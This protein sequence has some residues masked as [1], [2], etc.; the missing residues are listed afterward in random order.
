MRLNEE[1]REALKVAALASVAAVTSMG[2]AMHKRRLLP[3]LLA[4]GSACC[5]AGAI[6]YLDGTYRVAEATEI[7]DDTAEL[8]DE[9]ECKEAESRM[10][11]ASD[12][13]V[14]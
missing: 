12:E 9:A 3:A 1:E 13:P 7:T 5:A 8:L 14:D 10:A 2:L 6:S 4:I 11:V